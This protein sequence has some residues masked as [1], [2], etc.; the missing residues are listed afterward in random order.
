MSHDAVCIEIFDNE[1]NLRE[2]FEF[3]KLIN[4]FP[5]FIVCIKK[6]QQCWDTVVITIP[7][8][9]RHEYIKI[10]EHVRKI[11]QKINLTM[12]F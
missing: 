8:I 11:H 7:N 10:M 4:T 1:G 2:R 6:Q 3:G 9:K 5:R 12:K